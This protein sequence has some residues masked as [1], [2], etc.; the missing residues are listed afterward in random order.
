MLHCTVNRS[1]R[2]FSHLVAL[3]SPVKPPS[4]PSVYLFTFTQFSAFSGEPSSTLKTR[5]QMNVARTCVGEIPMECSDEYT[6]RQWCPLYE[7]LLNVEGEGRRKKTRRPHVGFRMKKALQV[8]HKNAPMWPCH[9]VYFILNLSLKYYL[10]SLYFHL[11]WTIICSWLK[12]VSN[13]K[14]Y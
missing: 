10:C 13:R 9:L 11:Q 8:I 12:V 14:H 3:C 6:C 1:P 2:V 4:L 5:K 7:V